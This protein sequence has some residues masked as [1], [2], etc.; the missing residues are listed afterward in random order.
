MNTNPAG[1]LHSNPAALHRR[2][3]VSGSVDAA[4]STAA[5]GLG[6]TPPNQPHSESTV[7]DQIRPAPTTNIAGY[8]AACENG[9]WE[10]YL[11]LN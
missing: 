8:R 2:T 11:E 6:A 7:S 10:A 9:A 1:C 3:R 4:K 5:A